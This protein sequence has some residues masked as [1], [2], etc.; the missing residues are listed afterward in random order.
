MAALLVNARVPATGYLIATT[1]RTG[2]WLLCDLLRQTGAAGRPGEYGSARDRATWRGFYGFAT[3]RT[4]FD[5]LKELYSTPNGVSGVKLMWPQL[6]EF[7][8]DA[9]GYL[10]C[11]DDDLGLLVRVF[12]R[13]SVVRLE[14]RD[15]L[16]QAISWFR[17]EQSGTW[18]VARG[19][20][21]AVPAGP[22]YDGPAIADLIATI[23]R[24]RAA[25]DVALESSGA[26][27]CPVFYEDLAADHTAVAGAV[28][29]FIG[30]DP[31]PARQLV[32]RLERLSDDLTEA[33]VRR[34]RAEGLG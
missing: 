4:Y 5:A 14:R 9:R 13:L 15:L 26:R 29:E 6:V 27:V 18:S 16:R 23:R 8:R 22:G 2:G 12:G 10:G 28:L 11:Q 24:Q 17:A 21:A 34:A 3:H 33:W 25:W 7:G 19:A 32:P 30:A 31:A 20:P 1:P